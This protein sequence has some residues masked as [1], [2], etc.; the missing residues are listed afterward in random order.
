[1]IREDEIAALHSLGADA[2]EAVL[3]NH[4]EAVWSMVARDAQAVPQVAVALEDVILLP[5][6]AQ[7]SEVEHLLAELGR[8]AAWRQE[9]LPGHRSQ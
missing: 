9:D 7:A 3:G 5:N 2:L 1:L 4:F 8:S 6:L